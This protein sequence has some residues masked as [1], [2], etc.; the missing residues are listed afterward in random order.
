MPITKKPSARM[1]GG[2]SPIDHWG[3]KVRKGRIIAE[4]GGVSEE[5]ARKAFEIASH[6]LPI[7]IKIVKKRY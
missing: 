1:G 4:I 6:K 3:A 5:V 2:K 7:K